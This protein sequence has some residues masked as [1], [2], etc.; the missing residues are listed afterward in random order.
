M[1]FGDYSD[2]LCNNALTVNLGL[3]QRHRN[4]F[5]RCFQPVVQLSCELAHHL[6]EAVRTTTHQRTYLIT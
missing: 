4:V 6:S 5:Q 3:L 2:V 1:R